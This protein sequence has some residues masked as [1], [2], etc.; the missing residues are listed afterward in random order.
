MT[1]PPLFETEIGRWLLQ[2]G[3]ALIVAAFAVGGAWVSTKTELASIRAEVQR[4][5]LEG[6]RTD[7]ALLPAIDSLRGDVREIK[8]FLCGERPLCGRVGGAR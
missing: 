2:R 7:R 1:T 3:L 8:R 6:T 4:I 5:D